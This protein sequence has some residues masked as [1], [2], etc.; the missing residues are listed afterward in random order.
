M[1]PLKLR[2]QGI[3]KP[4]NEKEEKIQRLLEE[5]KR[6]YPKGKNG[7]EGFQFMVIGTTDEWGAVIKH[8]AEQFELEQQRQAQ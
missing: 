1:D 6:Y 2:T 4:L 8:Q 7:M 5:N 3:K